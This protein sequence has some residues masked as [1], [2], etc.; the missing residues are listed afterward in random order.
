MRFVGESEA[1]G[2]RNGTTLIVTQSRFHAHRDGAIFVRALRVI[3][4]NMFDDVV[5][6]MWM[7]GWLCGN[8]NNTLLGA[9]ECKRPI[10]SAIAFHLSIQHRSLWFD[11]LYALLLCYT[12]CLLPYSRR[13]VKQEREK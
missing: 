11:V 12:P 4:E 13:A 2:R 3:T 6:M 1:N 10:I 9:G 7:C 5:W 8:T